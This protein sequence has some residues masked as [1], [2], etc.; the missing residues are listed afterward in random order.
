MREEI[1]FLSRDET[2]LF[3]FFIRPK[4][5]RGLVVVFAHGI[6]SGVPTSADDFGYLELCERASLLGYVAATMNFR[7]TGV[8]GGNF[9]IAAWVDD[10]KAFLD[11]LERLVEPNGIVLVGSSGGAAVSVKV[12][13]EN[14]KVIA[15]A[16]LACPADFSFI[17][18]WEAPERYVEYF[19]NIG[20]IRDA[21]FPKDAALWAEGFK[22]LAP[23]RYIGLL[24]I[25][26]LL[27]HGTNDEVV[28]FEHAL[29]LA[30]LACDAKLV[31]LDKLGH[32]LRQYPAVKTLVMEWLRSII[33]KSEMLNSG[34]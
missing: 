30:R 13:S 17:K 32:K 26:I 34:L 21:D 12:A 22:N 3:G 25:P 2:E 16:L 10:L 24:K 1:R 5:F 33:I 14:E 4:S 9:D 7:G 23:E 18:P 28:P 8:S 15:L 29:R 19:R 6:P 31:S 11:I 20:I 27:I